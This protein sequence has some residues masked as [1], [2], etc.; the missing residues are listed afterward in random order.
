MAHW[1]RH[2]PADPGVEGWTPAGVIDFAK[3]DARAERENKAKR[4]TAAGFEPTPLRT[5]AH[6]PSTTRPNCCHG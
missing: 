6:A 2:P 3:H 5:G 4:A 1:T